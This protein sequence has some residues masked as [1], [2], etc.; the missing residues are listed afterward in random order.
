[1]PI[2]RSADFNHCNTLIKTAGFDVH[3]LSSVICM[4]QTSF[5]VSYCLSILPYLPLSATV[6]G[7][8][9]VFVSV[10]VCVCVCDVFGNVELL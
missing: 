5:S 7:W 10:C 8:L 3:C 2:F 1:M 9:Y 6:F 4:T